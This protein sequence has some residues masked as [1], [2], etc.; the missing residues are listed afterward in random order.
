MEQ[1]GEILIG[2]LEV[3]SLKDLVYLKPLAPKTFR[4][5]VEAVPLLLF[6][7]RSGISSALTAAK[8][9]D[10]TELLP[11]SQVMDR[12]MSRAFWR[13]APDPCCC[14]ETVCEEFMAAVV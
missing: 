2:D 9:C 1:L 11:T 4:R 8:R 14:A 3:A 13:P 6:W 5:A 7:I 12:S 10:S